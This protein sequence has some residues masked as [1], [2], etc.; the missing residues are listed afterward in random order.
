MSSEEV[1][2]PTTALKRL[3]S[4]VFVVRK[5]RFVPIKSTISSS[6]LGS[7][8]FVLM[9]LR[10]SVLLRFPWSSPNTACISSP[11]ASAGTMPANAAWNSLMNRMRPSLS[12]AL[13]IAGT[14]S[15]TWA[16][17]SL[18]SRSA[19]SRV[20]SESWSSRARWCTKPANEFRAV[21]HWHL[22]VWDDQIG[23]VVFEPGEGFCWIAEAAYR[24]ARF[25]R[26][27][28]LRENLAV[29]GYRSEEHTAA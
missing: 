25:D 11:T 23:R 27:R 28:K 10:S 15:T 29:G 22:E 8:A 18:E 5:T 21:H 6:K 26:S 12:V 14:V 19:S 16:S 9:T 13:I 1:S 3:R 2:T 7:A 4:G 24:H 20:R 17:R